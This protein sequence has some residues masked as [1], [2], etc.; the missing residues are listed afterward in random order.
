MYNLSDLLCFTGGNW[1]K[2]PTAITGHSAE[3]AFTLLDLNKP[4]MDV[5]KKSLIHHRYFVYNED[6]Q[7][8]Q[9]DTKRVQSL[10]FQGVV[11]D[12]KSSVEFE[13]MVNSASADVECSR[14]SEGRQY[15][16]LLVRKPCMILTEGVM[17]RIRQL[18]LDDS[19][20]CQH[21]P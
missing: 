3:W 4:F 16:C 6:L 20:Q 10:L 9:F 12:W 13:S 5:I 8:I 17:L 1:K 15:D 21:R 19:F 14:A 11:W 7:F 18:L 2:S